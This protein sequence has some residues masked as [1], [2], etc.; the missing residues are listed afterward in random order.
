MHSYKFLLDI[1]II[2]LSTKILGLITKRFNMPQVVGALIA[3]LVLGPAFLGVITE[4][5]FI[6]NIAELGVI[7]LMYNAGLGTDIQDLKK[8]GKAAF[9]I[10]LAG[11]IVP[12]IG[13]FAVASIF[14]PGIDKKTLIQNAFIGVV[15]TAT[16]VSITVE[17]MSELGKL[18]TRSGNAILGAAVIDDLLGIIALTIIMSFSDQDANI[19]LQIVKII[20]FLAFS[21][22]VYFIT[23]KFITPFIDK[24]DG[25]A[26]RYLIFELS[27]CLLMSYAAEKLFGVSDITGAFIAGLMF[28]NSNKRTYALAKMEPLSYLFFSPIFFA[29]VGLKVQIDGIDASFFIITLSLCIVATVTKFIGCGFGAKIMGYTNRQCKKIGVGMMSRGEVAL[30]VVSKGVSVGL[31][32]QK[33][34]APLIITVV[35]SAIVAPV[36]LKIIYRRQAAYNYKDQQFTSPIIDDVQERTQIEA[37][38]EQ[39]LMDKD[40]SHRENRNSAQ[41]HSN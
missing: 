12:F 23:K 21:A 16:S 32:L 7:F 5:D 36:L 15:L 3:G 19:L 40:K 10:A 8:S 34:Y 24:H 27:V 11:V 38:T 28:S 35:F 2:L 25:L 18:H 13:G 20:G 41:E 30:I 22:A 39:L 17:T 4:T 14:N 26:R 37:M 31:A 29:S 6:A 9:V 1:A 33:F